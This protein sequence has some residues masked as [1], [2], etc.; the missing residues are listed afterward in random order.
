MI[1]DGSLLSLL[2]GGGFLKTV[3]YLSFLAWVGCVKVCLFFAFV[4]RLEFRYYFFVGFWVSELRLFVAKHTY[5]SLFI[6]VGLKERKHLYSSHTPRAQ[7]Q[8][9]KTKGMSDKRIARITF[10]RTLIIGTRVERLR[11]GKN[12]H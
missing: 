1:L 2:V 4:G 6:R 12:R 7:N 10:I 5:L 3:Y 9:S 8:T 11:K